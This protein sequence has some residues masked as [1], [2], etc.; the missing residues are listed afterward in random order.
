MSNVLIKI[1]KVIEVENEY[2]LGNASADRVRAQIDI[3][4]KEENKKKQVPWA[5][6]LLPKTFHSVPKKG[7]AVLVIADAVNEFDT[8]QRYYIGPLISQPQYQDFCSSENATTLLQMSTRTPLPAFGSGDNVGAFPESEDVAVVGRGLEDVILKYD[9]DSKSSEVDLRA[10]IRGSS[11][12]AVGN[13][14][15]NGADPAYIQLKYKQGMATGEQHEA[16]SMINMVA[17]RINIMSN[18][19]TTIEHDIKDPN[20]LVKESEIDSVMDRLHQVPLGD[21]LVKL[22]EIMKGAILHH[23]HPFHGMEQVGDKPGYIDQL[24]NFTIN[25]I[26]SE[27]VRIS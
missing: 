20:T 5:F 26:L 22:L 21:V 14:I 3:D 25:D 24:K 16:N 19:D 18:K 6:P 12:V 17:N 7:E 13:I 9:K 23:V 2:S 10:G 4:T 11:G 27:Y 8:G 1:G 15:F